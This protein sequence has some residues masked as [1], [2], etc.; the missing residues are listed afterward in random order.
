MVCANHLSLATSV[1]AFAGFEYRRQGV[2]STLNQLRSRGQS[3]RDYEM[4]SGQDNV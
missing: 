4:V 2:M 3:S 1:D